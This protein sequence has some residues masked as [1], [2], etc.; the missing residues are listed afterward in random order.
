MNTIGT[1]LTRLLN[2][3]TGGSFDEGFSS[4]IYND[5]IETDHYFPKFLVKVIDTLAI[6]PNHCLR[7]WLN[8]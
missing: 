7:A 3:I 5:S 1:F 4:R 6:E 2:K 8:H